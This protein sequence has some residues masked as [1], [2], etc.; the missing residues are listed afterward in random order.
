MLLLR[1][2]L[3]S[4]V[5]VGA[6]VAQTYTYDADGVLRHV[7]HGSTNRARYT[8]DPG[9]NLLS[10]QGPTQLEVWRHQ[11]FGTLDPVGAAADGAVGANDGVPNLVKYALGLAPQQQA[12]PDD[13][14]QLIK[15]SAGL[16]FYYWAR[17]GDERLNVRVQ[18][19][20]DLSNWYTDQLQTEILDSGGSLNLFK[21]LHSATGPKQFIRLQIDYR[22]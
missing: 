18:R 4:V 13:V 19:S 3:F 22:P 14:S 8:F 1:A 17:T 9:G 15:T 16:E 6:A 5:A 7:D 11:N 20:P 2:T 12:E 10:V 21:V